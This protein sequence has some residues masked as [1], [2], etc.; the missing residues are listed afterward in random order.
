M[1]GVDLEPNRP[2]DR[3][4]NITFR[5]C[6][7]LNNSGAGF[8]AFPGNLNSSSL[9]VTVRFED[10]ENAAHTPPCEIY[11]AYMSIV[12]CGLQGA[13]GNV[14]GVGLKPYGGG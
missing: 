3:L 7:A 2:T 14:S 11:I 12:S 9:P 1:A 4:H 5:R 13:T 6:K 10:C 8:Q